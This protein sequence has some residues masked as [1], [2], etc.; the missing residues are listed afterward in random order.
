MF[1][2][3][4]VSRDLPAR[5]W[6][7]DHSQGSQG[8]LPIAVQFCCAKYCREHAAVT[9]IVLLGA[10]AEVVYLFAL[11]EHDSLARPSMIKD[12]LGECQ[13]PVSEKVTKIIKV[14]C[15]GLPK[16]SRVQRVINSETGGRW[17]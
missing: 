14:A 10:Q 11:A 17:A 15:Y 7:P 13:V 8:S 9:S 4:N 6:D 2:A 5:C 16:V 12:S 3:E 1:A